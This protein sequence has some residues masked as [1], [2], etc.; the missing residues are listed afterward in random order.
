MKTDLQSAIRHRH[1]H[2]SHHTKV[3]EVTS[4]NRMKEVPIGVV[5]EVH[6]KTAIDTRERSVELKVVTIETK[7]F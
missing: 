7:F 1:R 5:I 3:Q 4:I 2:A 6:P